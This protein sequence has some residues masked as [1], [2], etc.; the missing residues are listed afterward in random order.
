MR[1]LTLRLLVV[2][3]SIGVLA[4]AAVPL[5]ILL[6]LAD[7]GT[8][9]GLCP[10][11]LNGCRAGLVSGPRLALIL[12]AFIFLLLAVLRAAVWVTRAR[13]ERARRRQAQV[14][15]WE[16]STSLW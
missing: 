16:A 8:G 3:V 7:G 12:V 10:T 15:E 4:L 1:P 5:L 11:G 9:W 14:D 6:D 2:F 13:I